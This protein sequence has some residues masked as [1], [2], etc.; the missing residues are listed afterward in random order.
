MTH[1]VQDKRARFRNFRRE[2]AAAVLG[3]D[4]RRGS[5]A[6]LVEEIEEAQRERG[7]EPSLSAAAF[8]A[9][10]IIR[11]MRKAGGLSQQQLARRIGVTQARISELEAGLGSRGPSWDLMERLA[12]ACGASILVSPP[13][14][15]L[16]VDVSAPAGEERRWT[17]A[18]AGD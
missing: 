3:D 8:R 1:S 11:M 12:Q 10:S 18:A 14:S 7:E 6:A 9:G 2:R 16:A 17:L 4:A 15:D 5:F 13:E